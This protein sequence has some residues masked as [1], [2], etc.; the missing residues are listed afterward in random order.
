M[1]RG[2][3]AV[4]DGVPA[5]AVGEGNGVPAVAGGRE[6]IANDTTGGEE[7]ISDGVPTEAGGGE[8]ITNDT[9]GGVG[10]A[11]TGGALHPPPRL[12]QRRPRSVL[13]VLVLLLL[14]GS[15]RVRRDVVSVA[16]YPRL[17][18]VGRSHGKTIIIFS[19]GLPLLLKVMPVVGS[20]AESVPACNLAISALTK[21][22]LVSGDPVFVLV[23]VLRWWW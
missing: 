16:V 8:A 3:A 23:C 18:G 7:A 10:G 1:V 4:A 15:P 17:K 19:G 11:D 22:P 6:V 9:T 5:V 21:A 2:E 12:W 13:L 14:L 20:M